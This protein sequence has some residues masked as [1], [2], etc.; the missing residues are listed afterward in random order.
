M[1]LSKE[2]FPVTMSH[3]CPHCGNP[4][5]RK[6]SWFASLSYYRCVQCRHDVTMTYEMKVELFARY[7]AVQPELEKAAGSDLPEQGDFVRRSG[8]AHHAQ[9]QHEGQPPHLGIRRQVH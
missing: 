9:P 7:A 3:F 2:L 1:V 8:P 6:G 4:L 5:R